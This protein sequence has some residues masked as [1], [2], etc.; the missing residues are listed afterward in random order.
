[1][2]VTISDIAKMADVSKSTVSRYLNNGYVSEVN[3]KKIKEAMEKTNYKTNFFAKA[4]NSDKSNLIGV[5]IPRFSSFSAN[6]CLKGISK[7]LKESN[8]EMFIAS[9]D[10]DSKEEL[11]QAKKFISMGVDGVIIM[12]THISKDHVSLSKE[13][14]I[15]IVFV[16]Q[17]HKDVPCLAIDDNQVGKIAAD[18]MK[19]KNFNKIMYMGV[20]QEDEAV[21]VY[22]K[23]GFIDQFDK[24]EVY[25]IEGD[26][27]FDTAYTLG[28][29]IIDSDCDA[30]VCA[31]DNMAIGVLKYF[32][33]QHINVP[34]DIS[35]MSFGNYEVSSAIHPPLTTVSINYESLGQQST[36]YLFNLIKDR[37]F[38]PKSDL[39]EDFY[40][41][42][43][44]SVRR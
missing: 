10:L 34:E 32:L 7:K 18:F 33:E 2:K 14:N 30:L 28:R 43:R 11:K 9:S 8:Y 13:S 5:I 41:I 39:C 3:K 26:F 15:P 35:V 23:K 6:Q 37:D 31:T 24:D 38:M 22:R 29:K 42:V 27:N 44:D 25:Y 16:G 21:G 19:E 1:M 40:L 12:T 17:T 4:L 36:S 20:S